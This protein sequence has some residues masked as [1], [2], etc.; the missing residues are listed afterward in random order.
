MEN[1]GITFDGKVKLMDF[2]P[3]DLS[4]EEGAYKDYRDFRNMLCYIMERDKI[5]PLK[6]EV[7]D[8]PNG[9]W[10]KLFSAWHTV[11]PY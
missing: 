7:L 4:F 10:E 3:L 8:D 2:R 9:N 11:C 5:F 1:I 6:F